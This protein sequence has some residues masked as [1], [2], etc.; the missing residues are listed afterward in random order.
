MIRAA[1]TR[2]TSHGHACQRL[3]ERNVQVLDALD[4]MIS[5]KHEPEIEGLHNMLCSKGTVAGILVLCDIL[6]PDLANELYLLI[7]RFRVSLHT[8]DVD[9]YFSRHFLMK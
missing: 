2:W 9:L 8:P 6:K 4:G 5:Q 7:D 3:I 1:A